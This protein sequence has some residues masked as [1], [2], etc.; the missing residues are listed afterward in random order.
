MGHWARAVAE[1]AGLAIGQVG[2]GPARRRRGEGRAERG[3][4]SWLG[5]PRS[6]VLV[7]LASALLVGGGRKLLQGWRARAAVGRLDDP[8][9]TRAEIED[10]VAYGR[11][12]LIEL[13]RIL[14]TA[15]S[16]PIRHAAGH[17]LAVLWAQDNLIAEEEQALVRRGYMVTWRARRRY[18]RGLRIAIPIGVSYGIPFLRDGDAGIGASNLEWSHRILGAERAALE[19]FTPWR[20]GPGR[21]EFA[22]DPGDFAAPGPHR[23]VLQARVRTTGLTGTWELALPQIPFNFELDP[24]LSVDALLTLPDDTRA[25]A[26]AAAIRLERSEPA[27]PGSS[28]YLNLND[29]LAVRDPPLLAVTTPLPCDLAHPIAVQFDGVSGQFAAGAVMLSGQG[30]VSVRDHRESIQRFPL[31]PIVALPPGTID[32]PGEYR[33]RAL[34]VAAAERGWTDPDIRSIWPGAITTD[35]VPVRIVRR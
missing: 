20:A 10:V 26:I 17:A 33:L 22:L 13:F 28:T 32:R 29:E 18:P 34:L 5:D 16:E 1:W 6:A 31:G 7:V 11:A 3:W 27:E 8:D 30:P 24:R 9:V 15:P 21:A 14:G 35:W 23:L 2:V 12:G 19:S 4:S 25:A